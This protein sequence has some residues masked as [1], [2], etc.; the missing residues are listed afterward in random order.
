M[1]HPNLIKMIMQDNTTIMQGRPTPR[2]SVIP[3][4]GRSNP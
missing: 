2:V 1:Q 4:A 3:P